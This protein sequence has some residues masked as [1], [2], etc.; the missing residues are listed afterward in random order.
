MSI[1]S[2]FPATTD[3]QAGLQRLPVAAPGATSQTR[4]F[5]RQTFLFVVIGLLI[6]LGVYAVSDQLVYRYAKRN[7]FYAVKTAPYSDYNY[8]ILGASRAAAFDYEDMTAR[9]EEMTGSKILN[10]SVV[11]GGITIN[12]LLLE[13][14]LASHRTQSAV[15]VL[16]SFAFYSR[17][18]NEDRLSDTRLFDRAPFDP[19]LAVVLLQNPASR[20]VALDYLVGFSKINNPDRFKP[21][22]SNDEATRFNKTY[23]PVK[24]IDTQRMEYLYPKQI[25]PELF[26]HYLAEFE[27]LILYARQRNIQVIVIKPPIPESVYRMLPNE[28]KFDEA[29]KGV[30]ERNS[31]EFHDFS[32]VSNDEK[33]FFNTDHLNRNGVLNFFEKYLKGV[34]AR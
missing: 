1:E 30:L 2:D 16:D 28:G 26:Q 12:R 31:V 6:Y 7:R 33:F 10:L 4:S 34:L 29:L 25:E 19:T 9:L 14:F 32:L 21:D 13:Y 15:Y 18:W 5:L 20:A 8:V 11:G 22:I 23:R 17:Q 24:Q 3:L 27:D